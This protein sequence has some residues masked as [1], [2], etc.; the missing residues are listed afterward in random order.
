METGDDAFDRYHRESVVLNGV[1]MLA[2]V[3]GLL[4]SHV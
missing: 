3:V 2:V 4:A 1:T